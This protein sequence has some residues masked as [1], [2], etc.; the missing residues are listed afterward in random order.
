MID[1]GPDGVAIIDPTYES[2]FERTLANVEKCG[3]KPE[4]NPLGGQ[5]ALP[6]GSCHGR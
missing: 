3:R 4:G 5:H 2:E 1:C 6:R